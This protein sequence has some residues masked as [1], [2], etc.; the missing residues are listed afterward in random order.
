MTRWFAWF[1]EG[2][3]LP[4]FKLLLAENIQVAEMMGNDLASRNK[5]KL[6]GIIVASEKFNPVEKSVD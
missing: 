4:S 1:T 6:I 5:T 2:D 3:K